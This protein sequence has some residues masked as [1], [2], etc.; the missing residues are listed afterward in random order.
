MRRALGL[1]HCASPRLAPADV[2]AVLNDLARLLV[3]K[4]ETR[5]GGRLAARAVEEY[6]QVRDVRHAELAEVLVTLAA[7]AVRTGEFPEAEALLRRGRRIAELEE[8]RP[9]VKAAAAANLGALWLAQGRLAE[10][11][12]SWRSPWSWW[13][14]WWTRTMPG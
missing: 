5:E 4:G 1:A 2:G 12:L 14:R 7:V 13:R 8:A 10:A 11:S 9:V 3:D 6:A